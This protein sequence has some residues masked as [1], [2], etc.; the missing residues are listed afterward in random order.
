MDLYYSNISDEALFL[1]MTQGDLNAQAILLH[2]FEHAGFQ[3]L[4]VLSRKYCY[5]AFEDNDFIDVIDGAIYKSFRY[6]RLNER[7]FGPFCFDIL[8]QSISQ[9][10]GEMVAENLKLGEVLYLDAPIVGDDNAYFH[11][12]I[13]DNYHLSA[14]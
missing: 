2:R 5:F 11:E 3:C 13:S 7:K 6:Y 9:K 14:P 10:L 1:K 4:N 8:N 12:I